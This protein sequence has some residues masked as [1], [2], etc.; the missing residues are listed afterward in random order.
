MVLTKL[1]QG[2]GGANG[3]L[4]PH[5]VGRV[6]T[7]PLL[8]GNTGKIGGILGIRGPS[9]GMWILANHLLSQSLSFHTCKT[10]QGFQTICTDSQGPCLLKS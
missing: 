9:L 7:Q 2:T 5:S 6:P 3:T 1:V 4:V 8:S 10:A